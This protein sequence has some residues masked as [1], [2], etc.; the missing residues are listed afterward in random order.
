MTSYSI[1]TNIVPVPLSAVSPGRWQTRTTFDGDRLAELARSLQEH[2]QIEPI[3][4]WADDVTD[5]LEI[6]AGERRWR[7]LWAVQQSLAGAESLDTWAHSAA[8]TTE[9]V[10]EDIA[11]AGTILIRRVT[12]ED[13]VDLY[14]LAL[15]DNLERENLSVIEEARGLRNLQSAR[16]HSI[17]QLASIASRSRSW[18]ADRLSLLKLQPEALETLAGRAGGFSIALARHI[19]KVAE[20]YQTDLAAYLLAAEATD[21]EAASLTPLIKKLSLMPGM[22]PAAL[23]PMYRRPW[24]TETHQS[25][26]DCKAALIRHWDSVTRPLN[27]DSGI[28][29]K[30]L[31][32]LDWNPR[33]VEDLLQ[34]ADL[35]LLPDPAAC[36]FCPHT[37]TADDERFCVSAS[38]FDR[39]QKLWGIHQEREKDQADDEPFARADDETTDR[40]ATR[41]H[42]SGPVPAPTPIAPPAPASQPARP[43]PTMQPLPAAPKP[44][45]LNAIIRPAEILADQEV[46][47]TIHEEGVVPAGMRKGRYSEMAD[48][49][50]RVCDDFFNGSAAGELA[51][52]ELETEPIA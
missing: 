41:E 25:I 20:D 11:D 33:L 38:C 12:A 23:E 52:A 27:P 14:E 45:F 2:G 16:D 29:N 51:T 18:V 19:G 3:L 28:W 49:V 9:F 5:T 35:E 21:R 48:L 34:P 36:D 37:A 44:V 10:S 39:K 15:I 24:G 6:V 26:R 42:L 31:F 30:P 22:S 17:S 50:S 4:I 47:V 8:I 46:I 43:L 1:Q 40:N 7:A 32:P 13:P